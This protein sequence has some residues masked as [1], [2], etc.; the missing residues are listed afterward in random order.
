MTLEEDRIILHDLKGVSLKVS[1]FLGTRKELLKDT[2]CISYSL[3]WEAV[4]VRVESITLREQISELDFFFNT[5]QLI[6]DGHIISGEVISFNCEPGDKG[7]TASCKIVL[8]R[9]Y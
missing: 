2:K 4:D 1:F 8:G 9:D 3:C 7:I 5:Q 6:I